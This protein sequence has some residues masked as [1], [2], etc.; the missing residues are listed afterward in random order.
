MKNAGT[1]EGEITASTSGNMTGTVSTKITVII[2]PFEITASNVSTVKF[3][4][5][6]LSYTG[7]DLMSSVKV[8]CG[9]K[10]LA[11]SDYSIVWKDSNG[12]V[13]TEIIEAGEYTAEITILDGNFSYTGD[14]IV[15]TLTV[16]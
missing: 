5:T 1:Y 14:T 16:S 4:K 3:K 8:I 2:T 10:Q 6:T 13:V 11:S 12:D 7:S 15:R 9:N